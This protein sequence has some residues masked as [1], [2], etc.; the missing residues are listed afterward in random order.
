MFVGHFAVGFGAKRF[1]PRVSLGTLFL[2]ARF[3]DLLCPTLL[4][5]GVEWVRFAPGITAF[6]PLDFEHYP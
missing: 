6:T 5:F 3:I 2:A 4:L 1:A